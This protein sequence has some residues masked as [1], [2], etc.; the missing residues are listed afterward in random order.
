MRV[1]CE[2]SPCGPSYVRTGWANVFRALGH[3]FVWWDQGRKPALDAFAET[4]PDLF[5]GT[6]YGIDRATIKAIAR[7]PAMRVI[8]YASAWGDLA[9]EIPEDYPITRVTEDEKANIAR[10]KDET[11]RPDFVFS[12]VSPTYQAGLLG[13]WLTHANICH[14]GI[15][16]AADTFSYLGATCREEFAC[17][18]AFVGGYWPY[19]ARNLGPYML[20]L[21]HASRGLR[22]KIFG[23]QPWPVAQ[24]LGVLEDSDARDVFASATVCPNVSEPHS[25]E[26]GY[27]VVERPFKVLA[28]GGFCVSDH[29]DGLRELFGEDEVPTAR[30]PAEFHDL[31][32][33]FVAHPDDRL[34]YMAM[35]RANVMQNH[36]YFHR[37]AQMLKFLAMYEEEERCMRIHAD[38]LRAE[39]ITS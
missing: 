31:V 2:Y 39:G 6:T 34:G 18:V 20:P 22:V 35:A 27:D 38:L 21:C 37:V 17:D 19:K 26:F 4:A 5:I 16:N 30:T 36:T 11:G 29:V 15:L 28:A 1:L 13:G 32:S 14:V 23:N 7:R 25:T 33:H 9:D 24:Y 10:L 12:H 3:E 8:L